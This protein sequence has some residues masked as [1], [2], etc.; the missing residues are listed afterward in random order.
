MPSKQALALARDVYEHTA[1]MNK[2][3]TLAAMAQVIDDAVAVERER[4]AKIALAYKRPA[5]H[6]FCSWTGPD[7]C[8]AIRKGE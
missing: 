1:G 4:C 2:P 6:T 8:T 3:Q 5:Y 7:I